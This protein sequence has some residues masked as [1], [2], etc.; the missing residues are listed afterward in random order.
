VLAV[1]LARVELM[2]RPHRASELHREHVLHTTRI[3]EVAT[4]G[5][6]AEGFV[7]DDQ[8]LRVVEHAQHATSMAWRRCS[9]ER[10]EADQPG[11]S[12]PFACGAS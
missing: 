5:R 3:V 10:K 2:H 4:G 6:R 11:R 8:A 12:L 7:D 1:Q 9:R